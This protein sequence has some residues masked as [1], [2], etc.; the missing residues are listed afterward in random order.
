MYIITQLAYSRI[1]VNA[2]RKVR[3]TSYEYGPVYTTI[4]E[5]TIDHNHFVVR[6]NFMNNSCVQRNKNR[7]KLKEASAM[8]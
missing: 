5:L 8:S 7:S 3:G 4:C 6:L 1:A 2:I